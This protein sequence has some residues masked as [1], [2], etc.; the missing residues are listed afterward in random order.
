MPVAGEAMR[1]VMR[2]HAGPVTVV[3]SRHGDDIYG[4]TANSVSSVSLDPPLVL[5]CIARSSYLHELIQRAGC[6]AVNILNA[7]QRA[8]AE[9][10][11]RKQTEKLDPFEALAHERAATGAPVFPDA[12]GYLDCRLK[13]SYPGGDH[14][15]FVGEV[16]AAATGPEGRPLLYFEG[17]YRAGGDEV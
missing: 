6:F 1:R 10:F 16:E 5:V 7:E 15:I 17:R 9:R 12:L 13:Y 8:I 4:I 11:A 3:T 2:R 14:T